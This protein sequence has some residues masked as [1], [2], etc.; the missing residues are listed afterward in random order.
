MQA[1]ASWLVVAIISLP[2]GPSKNVTLDL[3][4]EPVRQA[5]ARVVEA[6]GGSAS[7]GMAEMEDGPPVTVKFK[8][9]NAE[10]AL[11]MISQ[12]AGLTCEKSPDDPKTMIVSQ[13][14]WPPSV[15]LEGR[16]VPILGAFG[17]SSGGGGGG[18]QLVAA[19][20]YYK[21][22][23]DQMEAAA[24]KKAGGQVRPAFGGDDTLVD[25]DVKDA[26]LTQVADE[27]TRQLNAS[28]KTAK[29]PWPD[30]NPYEI[31]VHPSLKDVKVTAKV[32]RW[33]VGEVLDMILAQGNLTCNIEG[34]GGGYGPAVVEAGTVPPPPPPPTR[35][36]IIPLPQ[37]ELSGPGI[38]VGGF[39]PQVAWERRVMVGPGG[40]GGGRGGGGGG[41]TLGPGGGSRIQ[42]PDLQRYVSFKYEGSPLEQ[43]LRDLLKDTN[44]YFVL[45]PSLK[46]LRIVHF[47]GGGV[48]IADALATLCK[49]NGLDLEQVGNALFFRRSPPAAGGTTGGGGGGGG[50]GTG[51]QE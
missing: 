32:Y 49:G 10:K 4:N 35:I 25:L 20:L 38:P 21:L 51:T 24:A 19:E 39:R 8:D 26:P 46:D 1:I 43:V 29:L 33:P 16:K 31:V 14:Q 2:A 44:H 22:A 17:T 30:W 23:Q 48:T 42:D 45:D 13:S 18:S 3:K 12:A 50:G 15:T 37:L 28:V 7:F 47:E 36:H 41:A 9:V 40:G 5:I 34:A 6:A 11:T 27:L